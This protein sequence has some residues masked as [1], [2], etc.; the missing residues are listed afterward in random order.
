MIEKSCGSGWI[1]RQAERPYLR[2]V[3]LHFRTFNRVVVHENE[4]LESKIQFL[5][6]GFD[7]L[8]LGPPV[9]PPANDMLA[10]QCHLRSPLKYF[11]NILFVVLAAKAEEHA[12]VVLSNH[13]FLDC[14]SRRINLHTP[15]TILP[16]HSSPQ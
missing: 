5:G 1:L 14:P 10:L 6:Q 4:A 3:C 2:A 7:I 11:E 12:R 15:C 8:R 13:K 16:A 9:N